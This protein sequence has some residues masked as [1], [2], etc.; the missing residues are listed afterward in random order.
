[1]SAKDHVVKEAP[2]PFTIADGRIEVHQLRAW[3]DN[4]IWVMYD[5]ETFDVV[6]I[7]G[8]TALPV[9]QWLACRPYANISIWNTHHH[10]DHI[11]INRDFM[12][13][14]QFSLTDVYGAEARRNNIPGLTQAL[15]EGDRVEFAE[16][17]FEVW[18][19]D[20]HVDGHLCFVHAELVFCGDTLFAGGC[21]YLFDG[22]PEAMFE[23]L[24]RLAKLDGHV[25]VCCA[26]EYTVD[27]LSFA[28]FIQPN[29]DRVAQRLAQ[30]V[31]TLNAGQTTLP[32]TI[33]LERHTNPFMR[34]ANHELA[35]RVAELSG[36]ALSSNLAVFAATRK[37]KDQKVH[38]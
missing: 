11:G 5:T 9:Y 22:P 2:V 24:N 21:G 31:T 17:I 20:G 28:H 8:P 13:D 7:D 1:M 23:S 27:N 19:T 14:G 35:R 30:A 18:Q 4:F 26:H 3:T 12:T 33:Q 36:G 29:E 10:H 32:S 15:V 6:I 25:K 16:Q 34:S 38:R 37:L